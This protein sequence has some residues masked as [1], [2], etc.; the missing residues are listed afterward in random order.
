[1]PRRKT[2]NDPAAIR[3][4]FEA[5]L[6]GAGVMFNSEKV[7]LDTLLMG[8][9]EL[10][11]ERTEAIAAVRQYAESRI[12]DARILT[13]EA[14][15]VRD[16]AM[17]TLRESAAV[18]EEAGAGAIDGSASNE[19]QQSQFRKIIRTAAMA[20]AFKRGADLARGGR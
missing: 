1:M 2:K 3:A 11:E 15:K 7:S 5:A 4:R 10:I 8:A 20:V 9:A 14:E 16:A 19:R 6:R 18:L 13:D 17:N 12:Q